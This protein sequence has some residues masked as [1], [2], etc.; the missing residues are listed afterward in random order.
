MCGIAG[1]ICKDRQILALDEIGSKMNT[2]LLNRGPDDSGIWIDN[3]IGILLSHTRLS[4][5]DLSKAGHQPMLSSSNRFVLTFNG[6]IYNH[7]DL[8]QEL[9]ITQG[10]QNWKSHSDTETLIQ[11]I[12]CWGVYKTLTKLIGMFAFGIF[13]RKE[14]KFYLARDRFG[15]KPIY[16]GITDVGTRKVLIF[17]SDLKALKSYPEFNNTINRESMGLFI[18]YNYV[19]DPHSIYENI[20]KLEAGKIL[21][22]DV[23]DDDYSKIY[24]MSWWQLEDTIK[25]VDGREIENESEAINLLKQELIKSV[26]SQSKA[27][28]KITSFLSGGIDSSL[29]SALLQETSNSQINTFTIGFENKRFDEATYAR[30]ISNYLGSNHSE[31]IFTNEDALN[32]VPKI[33]EYYSEPF[34]D[35]AAIPTLL[36]CNAAKSQGYTVALSGDG[37]DEL[38]GGY[39]RYTMAPKIWK[40]FGIIPNFM[41]PMLINSVNKLSTQ[42]I[43]LIGSILKIRQFRERLYKITDK[44]SYSN[45][46]EDLY[47]RLI[48]EWSD[49]SSI[50]EYKYNQPFTPIS[51]ERLNQSIHELKLDPVTFMMVID[52]LSY[53]PGNNQ[54]KLDRASMAVGLETRSPFL[55]KNVGELIWRLPINLKIKNNCGKY[56]L[57]E[58]LADY[59]PKK[60]FERPK[61][62]FAT[63]IN[64][65]IKGPLREWAEEMLNSNK[66]RD[67]GFLNPEITTKLLNEHIQG[68]KD[69]SKKLWSA[70]IW[71]SWIDK[72]I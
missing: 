46:L 38:F 14:N 28:V 36:L 21:E 64:E 61:A 68:V 56:I 37:A 34:A 11:A 24:P 19:P 1:L 41:K 12:E 60:L 59:I 8:R 66:V 15:E 7:W 44:I 42:S 18:N 6:E 22:I 30:R 71:E 13:D 65:W 62:G 70:L 33:N 51:N 31:L 40:Y 23:T 39:N 25:N 67:E 3:D 5:N 27:D 20:W 53:L 10:S 45:S 9:E 54:V 4:V 49:V 29:V 72:N 43:D 57:K 48:R 58:I 52:C 69:N 47:Y 2:S 35:P 32:I 50:T 17:G 16:W 63:P 26:K 55:D